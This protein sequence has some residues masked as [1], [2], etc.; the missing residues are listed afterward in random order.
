MADVKDPRQDALAVTET[1][2]AFV[3]DAR[4]H[5]NVCQPLDW[6]PE[7]HCPLGGGEAVIPDALLYY[8]SRGAGG[9]DSG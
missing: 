6:N 5:R 7:V 2:L 3:Q 8:R 4:R 9:E 1:G